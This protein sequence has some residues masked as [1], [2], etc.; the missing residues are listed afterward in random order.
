VLYRVQLHAR[1]SHDA[2]F[3]CM[4]VNLVT[5][6]VVGGEAEFLFA[7]YSVFTVR[8]VQWRAGTHREP[9]IVDVDAAIDNTLESEDLPLAPWY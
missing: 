4:Q 3:R 9:H 8:C 1:G 6:G 5:G 7:P 2:E